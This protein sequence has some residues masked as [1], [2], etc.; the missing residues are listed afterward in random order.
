MCKTR[1]GRG[2]G[3]YAKTATFVKAYNTLPMEKACA[4]KDLQ[5]AL[6]MTASGWAVVT[7]H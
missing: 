2:V 3:F 7:G 5:T 4:G 6:V 1:L